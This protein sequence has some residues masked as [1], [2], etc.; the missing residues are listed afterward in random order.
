MF[1]IHSAPVKVTCYITV[2]HC[3][4]TVVEDR[5]VKALFDS[6]L[7]VNSLLSCA[8]VTLSSLEV[9]KTPVWDLRRSINS[10]FHPNVKAAD[11]FYKNDT[12]ILHVKLVWSVKDV[13]FN[14]LA[15]KYLVVCLN[16]VGNRCVS[17]VRL[18]LYFWES[19]RASERPV[20]L[21]VLITGFICFGGEE[22]SADNSAVSDEHWVNP[23]LETSWT[24]VSSARRRD[25]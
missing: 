22:K 7:T 9:E 1:L 17:F 10:F 2:L 6:F 24:D 14:I 19:R 5:G 16:T 8:E 25:I 21:L 18:S 20:F 4:G 13:I 3:T 15:L 12:Q 23:N 11:S